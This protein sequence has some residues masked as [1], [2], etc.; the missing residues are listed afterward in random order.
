VRAYT[1]LSQRRQL[2]N[3]CALRKTH[4][5]LAATSSE[6]RACGR[7][8]QEWRS[9]EVFPFRSVYRRPVQTLERVAHQ[10]DMAAACSHAQTPTPI[11]NLYALRDCMTIFRT[12]STRGHFEV[13]SVENGVATL[14][15]WMLHPDAPVQVF[16]AVV[17]GTAIGTAAPRERPD[18]ERR[19][20]WIPHAACSGFKFEL[21]ASDRRR[22]V[23]VRGLGADP[24]PALQSDL[25]F[26]LGATPIPPA[27][28]MRRATAQTSERMF[29]AEAQHW[30]TEFSDLINQHFD[31]TPI[32]RLLDWGCG[33]GR[34]TASLLLRHPGAEIH[35]CDID[36]EAVAWCH[37]HLPN[38]IFR[39]V[40]P[41]P[42]TS[43]E[44]SFFDVVIA[45]SVLTHLSKRMQLLW[46]REI[47]R[48]VRPGGLVVAS[49]HGRFATAFIVGEVAQM[50]GLS[51]WRGPMTS[52]ALTNG[53]VALPDQ[54]FKNI[55][56]AGYYKTACQTLEFTA[57]HWSKTFD[58]LEYV[59]AALG[60]QDLV[61]M[62][63]RI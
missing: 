33:C 1:L 20:R 28:L 36:A 38:G 51:R 30:C 18:V 11:S 31:D 3:R 7:E 41:A 14:S 12:R 44:T 50:L 53:F 37:E 16:E 55:A 43:Y 48:I 60:F 23:V 19:Y 45:S 56:P 54:S 61:A 6:H 35:G 25:G 29:R 34:L 9:F 39:R 26:D 5:D 27:P 47:T 15:G 49:L 32:Q 17:D 21:P 63:R 46:L 2:G 42:P 57:R 62:R 59:E 4:D 40:D 24:T 58:V 22:R 13:I 52:V 10:V 8:D